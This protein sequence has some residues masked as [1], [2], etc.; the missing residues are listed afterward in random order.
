MMTD[1]AEKG[2]VSAIIAIDESAA[3]YLVDHSILGKKLELIG[4]DEGSLEWMHSYMSDRR[5][6]V[7]VEG[8]PSDPIQHPPT[9]VTQG[10]IG[11]SVLYLIYTADLLEAIHSQHH[12]LPVDEKMHIWSNDDI[13]G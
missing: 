11:S 2:D 13:C 7:E 12:N 3:F 10:S 8:F 9:S 5:Q 6:S 1:K 4:M